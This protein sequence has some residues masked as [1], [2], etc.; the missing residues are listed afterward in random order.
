M[1]IIPAFSVN[2]Y[3]MLGEEVIAR[4]A[5]LAEYPAKLSPVESAAVWMQYVTAYGALIAVAHLT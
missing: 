5:A 4:A 1:A 2:D 3:A